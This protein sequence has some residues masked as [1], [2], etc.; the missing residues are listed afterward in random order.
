MPYRMVDM[1]FNRA[2]RKGNQGRNGRSAGDSK[3]CSEHSK[4]GNEEMTYQLGSASAATAFLEHLDKALRKHAAMTLDQLR[5]D[6]ASARV[7]NSLAIAVDDAIRTFDAE[8]QA[9]LEAVPET[10]ERKTRK[11]KTAA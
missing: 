4:I 5:A 6:V 8:L 2:K 7:S 1:M 10:T 9:E 11:S 3:N